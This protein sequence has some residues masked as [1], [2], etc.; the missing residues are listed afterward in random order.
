M[1]QASQADLNGV[2]LMI[3]PFSKDMLFKIARLQLA[4]AGD[5]GA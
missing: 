5:L 3:S 4:G 1:T 2:T